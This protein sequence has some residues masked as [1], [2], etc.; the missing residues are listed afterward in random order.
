MQGISYVAEDMLA[1]QEG[2]YSM[3]RVGQSVSRLVGWLDG[4][5]LRNQ[6]FTSEEIKCRKRIGKYLLP[7]SSEPSVFLSAL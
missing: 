1:S 6:N 2:L 4:W 3:E 5:I 7:F